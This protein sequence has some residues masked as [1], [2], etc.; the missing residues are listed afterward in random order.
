[1]GSVPAFTLTAE[2]EQTVRSLRVGDKVIAEQL[3]SRFLTRLEKA[4]G[5][6]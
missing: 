2:V 3:N 5:S 4:S 1:M 6:E